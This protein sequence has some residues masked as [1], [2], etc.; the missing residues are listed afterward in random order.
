MKELIELLQL[1]IDELAE[2]AIAQRKEAETNYGRGLNSGK[3]QAYLD[4]SVRVTD[5]LI[6][7]LKEENGKN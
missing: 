5:L 4:C 2:K 3:A 1:E 7:I 6:Y